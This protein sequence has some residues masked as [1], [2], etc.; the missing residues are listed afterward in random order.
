MAIRSCNDDL[1]STESPASLREFARCGECVAR[2]ASRHDARGNF[3]T[4]EDAANL[5]WVRCA[6][7]RCGT[8]DWYMR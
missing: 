4:A 2:I 1:L 8:E 7:C 3:L 6:Q 5:Q